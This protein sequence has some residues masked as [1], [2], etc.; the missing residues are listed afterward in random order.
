MAWS[1]ELGGVVLLD[2][3]DCEPEDQTRPIYRLLKVQSDTNT[4]TV[5]YPMPPDASLVVDR[6]GRHLGVL[7]SATSGPVVWQPG[8][9]GPPAET[10]PWLGQPL[11]RGRRTLEG[12]LDTYGEDGRYAVRHSPW[13]RRDLAR[14]LGPD[15]PGV[16]RD[17]LAGRLRHAS[18]RELL[19][20][21]SICADPALFDAAA[22]HLLAEMRG[23]DH[24]PELA[25]ELALIAATYGRHERSR[26]LR[27][28]LPVDDVSGDPRAADRAFRLG[29]CAWLAGDFERAASD[30]GRWVDDP[31]M[32]RCDFP[33]WAAQAEIAAGGFGTERSPGD[34]GPGAIVRAVREVDAAAREERWDEA[35]AMLASP[36]LPS[37]DSLSMYARRI[38][39]AVHTETPHPALRW[40]AL[41]DALDMLSS[42]FDLDA[43]SG[44]ARPDWLPA[45]PEVVAEGRAAAEQLRRRL[46]GL[47]T[48]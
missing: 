25:V 46:A 9:S 34:A 19:T 7:L 41:A 33:F 18:A 28:N 17:A 11:N 45:E 48:V 6:N 21:A 13:V 39:V 3:T 29:A 31:S 26:E 44:G 47:A 20:H 38:W 8:P 32:T 5:S 35:W 16:F 1:D 14:N 37:V 4:E 22:E 36:L 42:G 10:Q 12:D 40:F 23:D 2:E 27:R 30:W 24:D 43:P 15:S